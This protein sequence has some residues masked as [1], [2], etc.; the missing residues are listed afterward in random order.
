MLRETL[1]DSLLAGGLAL[2]A[3]AGVGQLPGA[4]RVADGHDLLA[5]LGQA[6]GEDLA[7]DLVRVEPAQLLGRGSP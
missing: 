7:V 1:A 5:D 4:L 6:V 3:A 2:A